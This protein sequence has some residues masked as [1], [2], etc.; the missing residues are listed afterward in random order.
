[1]KNKVTTTEINERFADIA[2]RVAYGK[3]IIFVERHGK[4]VVA[5]VPVEIAKKIEKIAV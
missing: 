1:M 2:N 3:E 5:I 4:E